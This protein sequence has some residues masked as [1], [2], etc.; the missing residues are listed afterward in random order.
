MV[1]LLF[2]SERLEFDGLKNDLG[3]FAT[4]LETILFYSLIV[5]R[6]LY[7]CTVMTV[8]CI[9]SVYHYCKL[10]EWLDAC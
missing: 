10:V 7:Y 3:D 9:E 5:V 2:R 4:Y 8:Y 1:T 6:I